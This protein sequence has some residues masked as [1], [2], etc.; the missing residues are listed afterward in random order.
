MIAANNVVMPCAKFLQKTNFSF[1]SLYIVKSSFP[2]Y[3]VLYI[4]EIT[5]TKF[6]LQVQFN[7]G[8]DTVM[9]KIRFPVV[10]FSFARAILLYR[11]I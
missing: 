4:T 1:Q 3:C 10:S 7:D 2:C 6:I 11:H 5:A 9:F 8:R